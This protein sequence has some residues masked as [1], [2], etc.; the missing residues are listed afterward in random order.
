M[1]RTVN[2]ERVEDLISVFGS[3]D[4]NIKKIEQ[5]LNVHIA[6]RGQELKISGEPE[7]LDKAARTVEGLM[8]LAAKGETIDEQKVRYLIGLVQ[9]GKGCCVHHRQGQ[10]H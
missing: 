4:E 7:D 5:S 2:V 10:A 6:N 3:L 9:S 8:A 1:E